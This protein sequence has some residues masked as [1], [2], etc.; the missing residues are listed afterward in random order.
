M[1]PSPEVEIKNQNEN[2]PKLEKIL[3]KIKN[4][5]NKKIDRNM[6][7]EV[8]KVQS[9]HNIYLAADVD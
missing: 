4:Y 8:I 7:T 9:Y 6:I 2:F 5:S 1:F 3:E